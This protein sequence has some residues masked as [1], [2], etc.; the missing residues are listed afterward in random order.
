MSAFDALRRDECRH[1][2]QDKGEADCDSDRGD[3]KREHA[4]TLIGESHDDDPAESDTEH[5]P[6]ITPTTP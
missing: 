6:S 4:E 1:R 2:R 5:S 3:R